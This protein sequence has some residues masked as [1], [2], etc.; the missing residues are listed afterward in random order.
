MHAR[1]LDNKYKREGPGVRNNSSTRSFLNFLL[2]QRLKPK[3]IRRKRLR[4]MLLQVI[5]RIHLRLLMFHQMLRMPNRSSP[6]AD[7]NL[8]L[9][10]QRMVLSVVKVVLEGNLLKLAL[11]VIVRP[12]LNVPRDAREQRN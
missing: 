12:R 6:K 10:R 9:V 4:L 7:P 3:R 8:G 5:L 11:H 2:K 1:M